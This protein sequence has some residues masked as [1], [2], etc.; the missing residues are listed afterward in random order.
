MI[1]L[2]KKPHLIVPLVAENSTYFTTNNF[3]NKLSTDTRY[4][5]T[6]HYSVYCK[7]PEIYCNQ[8]IYNAPCFPKLSKKKTSLKN[9][10]KNQQE[11]THRHKNI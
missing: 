9:E 6:T 4:Y 5:D 11:A 1:C 2:L 3:F 7:I 10:T 8:Q